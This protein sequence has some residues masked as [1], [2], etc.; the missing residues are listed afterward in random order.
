MKQHKEKLTILA[1]LLLEKEVIFKNDLEKIFGTRP[2]DEIEIE[3]D[4]NISPVEK[5]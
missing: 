2:F 5:V 4:K 1:E 3:K